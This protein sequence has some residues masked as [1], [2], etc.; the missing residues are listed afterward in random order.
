MYGKYRDTDLCE[1]TIGMLNVSQLSE[2]LNE[3]FKRRHEGNFANVRLSYHV[4]DEYTVL[5]HSVLFTEQKDGYVY[6]YDFTKSL[7]KMIIN[8]FRE[9]PVDCDCQYHT[10]YG[11]EVCIA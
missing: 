8:D 4:D 10:T 2:I 5:H 3:L 11:C 1:K 9:N 6:R 7:I